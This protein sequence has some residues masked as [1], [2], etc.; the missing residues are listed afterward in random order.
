MSVLYL[1]QVNVTFCE[2]HKKTEKK[3]DLA[4]V[5]F[6]SLLCPFSRELNY[7]IF[8]FPFQKSFIYLF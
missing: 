5:R 2:N 6:I 1:L 3:K 4:L 8:F 7:S